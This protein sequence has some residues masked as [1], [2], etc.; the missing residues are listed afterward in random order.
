MTITN[1]G[2]ESG[3]LTGW[4]VSNPLYVGVASSYTATPTATDGRTYT[5]PSGNKFVGLVAGGAADGYT[6]IAQQFDMKKGDILTGWS[7]FD[8]REPRGYGDGAL[9][10]IKV[11][12]DT[13]LLYFKNVAAVGSTGSSPWESWTFTAP[14]DGTYSL[15]FT[16]GNAV[17]NN[18][19][20]NSIGLFDMSYTAY[21]PISGVPDT[22]SAMVLLGAAVTA[23]EGFRRRFGR[24]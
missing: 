20:Y 8:A 15:G 14:Q 2:F 22:G 9:A 6:S 12:S 17:D 7:A 23:V 10:L 18:Q 19:T 4:L 24:A 11:L 5:A 3:D 13:T 16:V 1:P 21:T